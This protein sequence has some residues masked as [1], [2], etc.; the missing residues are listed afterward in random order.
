MYPSHCFMIHPSVET[1]AA[2]GE[3]LQFKQWEP[4]WDQIS[5]GKEMFSKCV[6]KYSSDYFWNI[7]PLFF[8]LPF[9][10]RT[11]SVGSDLKSS[12]IASSLILPILH[13]LLSVSLFLIYIY[14]FFSGFF[15]FFF[16]YFTKWETEWWTADNIYNYFPLLIVIRSHLTPEMIFLFVRCKQTGLSAFVSSSFKCAPSFPFLLS[17][18]SLLFL[19]CFIAGGPWFV[20]R[21]CHRVDA[22]SC[23]WRS[24]S[25]FMSHSHLFR[26]R[27][28]EEICTFLLFYIHTHL[29]AFRSPST[30]LDGCSFSTLMQP[31]ICPPQRQ[32]RALEKGQRAH[33]TS[34]YC[35][36]KKPKLTCTHLWNVVKSL[37]SQYTLTAFIGVTRASSS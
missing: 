6:Q 24:R 30:L 32:H 20:W 1:S 12:N 10:F 28:E 26:A 7:N 8:F 31:F 15:F 2:E 9:L 14:I 25:T 21:C 33:I 22:V 34:W 3:P 18:W 36:C 17:S 37:L 23:I 5:L 27:K 29:S 4:V 35:C 19:L 13:L 11:L 16:S